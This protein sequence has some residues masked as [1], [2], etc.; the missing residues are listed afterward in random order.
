QIGGID[1]ESTP[2]PKRSLRAERI[3]QSLRTA[4]RVVRAPGA[5]WLGTSKVQVRWQHG[6]RLGIVLGFIAVVLLPVSVSSVYL[7]LI[8]ADQYA[9]E[10]R[11]AVRGGSH[12]AFDVNSAVGVLA[13][14]PRTQ[15]TQDSLILYEY[16]R[17]R[18]IVEE[19]D[20]LINLR[21]IYSNP[22]ADF[23]A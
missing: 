7:G 12:P 21:Q 3:A 16:I 22:K 19:L 1:I 23:F 6:F 13:G 10:F 8:A 5:A 20:R 2:L 17:G 9:S 15:R 14:L 18:G 4:A 11:F